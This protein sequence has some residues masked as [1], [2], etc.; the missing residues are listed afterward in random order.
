[1]APLYRLLFADLVTDQ[2]LDVLPV[3]GLGFDDYIGKTGAMSGKIPVPDKGMADRVRAAVVPGRT[4][5]WVERG[6][7]IWWGGIV[8]TMTPS[9]DDRGAVSVDITAA[10]FDSYLDR[11]VVFTTQTYAQVDQLAIARGL[12]GYAASL[13]KGDLGFQMDTQLS[14]VLRDRTYPAS[15]VHRVREL[16]DDLAAVDNGFEW[17]VQVYRDHATG[18]RVKRLQFGYPKIQ[19]GAQPVMLTYPGNVLS[20]SMPTDATGMAN[21]WQSR[22]ANVDTTVDAQGGP[23]LSTAWLYTDRLNAGWPRLDGTSDYNSVSVKGT[24]D[25]HAKADLARARNATTIPSV[26][27]RL[28]G[29]ITPALIG[30]RARL[31]I[32]DVWYA[33]G[34][35]AT[36][37][38]VGLKVD[39]AE[40]GREESAELY[41][42]AT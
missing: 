37:R 15:E 17:R 13:D 18:A 7:D 16:L 25:N 36:Y 29:E 9:V 35:D 23:L 11:R 19:V 8:W 24:L 12:V 6:A 30:A 3:Q 5:V 27:V 28:D 33:D 40:R 42:E 10:T 41:L 21:V 26:R 14:G 22:G 20:Y 32:R 38:V 34:L 4:A 1:M 39:P 31:R 2:L